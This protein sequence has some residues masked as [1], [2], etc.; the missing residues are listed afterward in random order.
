VQD[1]IRAANVGDRIMVSPGRYHE[2]IRI[3]RPVEIF[4]DGH[5][6]DVIIESAGKDTVRHAFSLH[7]IYLSTQLTKC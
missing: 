2:T 5:V 6:S 7:S 3:D 4:G 1:A